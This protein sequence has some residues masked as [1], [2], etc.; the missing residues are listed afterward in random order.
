MLRSH[1]NRSA[2]RIKCWGAK[3]LLCGIVVVLF[4]SATV[5]WAETVYVDDKLTITFRSGPGMDRKILEYLTTGDHMELI[6][7]GE[8]WVLVR[9]PDGREGWVMKQY[10][11]KTKPS[12]MQVADLQQ[13]NSNLTSRSDELA[14]ENEALKATNQKVNA[15]LAEKTKALADLTTEYNDLKQSSDASSFQMRKY[16]IFFFSGAGILFIGILL[17]LVMKRQRR[18]SMYMI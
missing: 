16:L 18:K 12:T 4:L 8:E 14:N 5:A 10:I 3:G 15:A 11:T 6:E 17:G 13:A 7:D 9:L 1:H 2:T